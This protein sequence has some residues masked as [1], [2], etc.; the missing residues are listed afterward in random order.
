MVFGIVVQVEN[1]RTL[2]VVPAVGWKRE[3][4][5]DKYEKDESESS[6]KCSRIVPH[7]AFDLLPRLTQRLPPDRN[8]LFN[9]RLL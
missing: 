9:P 8:Q 7:R 6:P 4:Q 5:Q 1:L 2:L 3:D